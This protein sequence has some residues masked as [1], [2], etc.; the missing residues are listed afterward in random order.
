MDK[1]L[2]FVKHNVTFS[3][4]SGFERLCIIE[5]QTSVM[6]TREEDIVQLVRENVKRIMKV[7]GYNNKT[8]GE[9]WGRR[10]GQNVGQKLCG[11]RGLTISD[12]IEITEILN[13]PPEIFFLIFQ[14]IMKKSFRRWP[15]CFP[16]APALNRSTDP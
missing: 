5:G 14:V 2:D 8:L 7:R 13:V 12:I 15:S 3:L 11:K 6:E 10:T 4:P 9:K 1:A 16:G